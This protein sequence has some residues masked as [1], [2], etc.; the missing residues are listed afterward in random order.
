MHTGGPKDV[1]LLQKLFVL[2]KT[3]EDKKQCQRR[4]GMGKE[5]ARA[6]RCGEK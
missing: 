2:F 3:L 5:P 6:L 1:P 4:R